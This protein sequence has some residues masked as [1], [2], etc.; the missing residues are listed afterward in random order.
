MLGLHAVEKSYDAFGLGPVDLAVEDEVLAVLG[1]SGCG[2]TTLLSLVAGTVA[3]DAGSVTL[4]GRTLDGR[5]PEARG[6][7]LVFQDGA[8]FPHLT[9]RENVEYAATSPERVADLVDRLEVGHVLDQSVGALSGGER[10]RVALARSLATDP[11]ALLLD[12]PLTNLD[13]P[14]RR[15]LRFELR[16]LLAGLEIPVLYVTHDQRDATVVGDR[17]AVMRDGRLLQVGTPEAVFSRPNCPFVASFTGTSNLFRA[18][19]VDGD[20]D[21]LTLD[22]AG[23]TLPADAPDGAV[24]DAVEGDVWVSLRPE[25]VRLD[26]GTGVDV[27]LRGVVERE[28][29]EGDGYAVAVRTSAPDAT[30]RVRC[31]TLDYEA[32]GLTTGDDVRLGFDR[33][34]VHVMDAD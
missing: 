33:T 24:D 22:W 13:A 19:V 30:V 15:R 34:A 4:G 23:R 11:D 2:K 14:I 27:T 32:L 21:G 31:S 20:G 26:P 9:A 29:F 12:E 8:L 3:P 25:Y 5:P 6:T 18:R 17:V 16:D 28:R 1:P 7:V 10:Q